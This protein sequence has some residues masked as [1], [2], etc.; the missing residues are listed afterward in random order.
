MSQDVQTAERG[1]ANTTFLF[2]L[3]GFD[4]FGGI[5]MVETIIIY[6]KAG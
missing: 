6:G 5:L 4:L 3:F 2:V 1:E